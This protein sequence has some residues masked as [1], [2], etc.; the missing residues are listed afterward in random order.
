MKSSSPGGRCSHQ[1]TEGM[2]DLFI[3]FF[4]FFCHKKRFFQGFFLFCCWPVASWK[5]KKNTDIQ[6]IF[7]NS[8]ACRQEAPLECSLHFSLTQT[9][10]T[11]LHNS[12]SPLLPTNMIQAHE[13]EKKMCL[14]HRSM[15][16]SAVQNGHREI[17]KNRVT[18]HSGLLPG[19]PKDVAQV[20]EHH[21]VPPRTSD[22]SGTLRLATPV[23]LQWN[24][25]VDVSWTQNVCPVIASS[26]KP[27]IPERQKKHVSNHITWPANTGSLWF[28]GLFE[29][30]QFLTIFFRATAWLPGSFCDQLR[31]MRICKPAKLYILTIGLIGMGILLF[32]SRNPQA[33]HLRCI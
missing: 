7:K 33:N 1:I 4:P 21:P 12:T 31:W 25:T 24:L 6:V 11:S 14:D 29:G 19:H 28:L 17:K 13:N 18:N 26:T 2:S 3:P 5:W 27:E 15:A 10:W 22:S 32:W 23:K 8:W 9:D 20:L 16:W 30:W